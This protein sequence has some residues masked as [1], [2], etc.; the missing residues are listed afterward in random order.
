[1]KNVFADLVKKHSSRIFVVLLGIFAAYLAAEGINF[2]PHVS[3]IINSSFPEILQE[4]FSGESCMKKKEC[5]GFVE[6]VIDGDTVAL[7]NG[8]RVRYIGIDTPETV[9]PGEKVQ[10]LGK[11]SSEKN[12][13]LVQGKN[14]ML[15]RDVSDLDRYGRLLR[16]VYVDDIFVNEQLVRSGFAY[17]SSFPPDVAKQKIFE[18]AESEARQNKQGLWAEGVCAGQAE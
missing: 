18:A 14:V 10:C 4:N 15:V 13:E 7:S 12:R 17:A 9:H 11:E 1:M 16:Y 6:R 5:E 8:E 3:E 2:N